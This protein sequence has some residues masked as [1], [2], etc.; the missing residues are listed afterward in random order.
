[1]PVTRLSLALAILISFAF[2]VVQPSRSNAEDGDAIKKVAYESVLLW[3]SGTDVTPEEVF[4]QDYVN[5]VDSPISAEAP[6]DRDIEEL[7]KE[8]VQFHA[9]FSD[10]HVTSSEQV[11]Q[12]NLV[13][14]RV[15]IS[16]KHTGSLVGEKPT[17]NRVTYDS[18][19]FTRV[20]N[21][22]IV[23]T[24]VTWDKYGLYRQIGAIPSAN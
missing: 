11:A 17:G 8:L 22:K 9:A 6:S 2:L 5:H 13:A 14:T 21:G 3:M 16:A 24:W 19:E 7:K 4:T 15:V 23:E 10:V 12:G 1:M 20:E 18:V